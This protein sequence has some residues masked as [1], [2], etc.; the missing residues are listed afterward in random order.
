MSNYAEALE[1]L[2][3]QYEAGYL[4][5][6]EFDL[7]KRNLIKSNHSVSESKTIQVGDYFREYYVESLLEEG[8]WGSVYK[9]RHKF[10]F[11]HQGYRVLKVIKTNLLTNT[12]VRKRFLDKVNLVMGLEHPNVVKIFELFEE[13]DVSLLM[14]FVEGDSLQSLSA[15]STEQMLQWLEPICEAIDYIHKHGIVH[16]NIQPHNILFS[17]TRG[18]VILGFNFIT[19]FTQND[20]RLSNHLLDRIPYLAPEYF[21][22]STVEMTRNLDHY[23]VGMIVFHWFARQFPWPTDSSSTQIILLKCNEDLPSLSRFRSELK[24]TICDVVDSALYRDVSKR[25]SSST[26]FSKALKVAV[27]SSNPST[28]ALENSKS[29]VVAVPTEQEPPA[30]HTH[31]PIPSKVQDSSTPPKRTRRIKL[32]PRR[33]R[34]SSKRRPKPSDVTLH[35]AAHSQ[36]ESPIVEAS[37]PKPENQPLHSVDERPPETVPTPQNHVPSEMLEVESS[38]VDHIS[39]SPDEALKQRQDPKP[40]IAQST[41]PKNPNINDVVDSAAPLSDVQPSVPDSNLVQ[42]PL[43][44]NKPSDI[45]SVEIF[46]ID[47]DSL[48]EIF[49]AE[50]L[51]LD[52]VTAEVE[53]PTSANTT[54]IAPNS[55]QENIGS[56]NSASE[57]HNEEDTSTSRHPPNEPENINNQ[58]NSKTVN[59][60]WILSLAGILL[61]FMSFQVYSYYDKQ[62]KFRWQIEEII[63]QAGLVNLPRPEGSLNQQKIDGFKIFVEE[64]VALRQKVEENK[65]E[66]NALFVEIPSNELSKEKVDDFIKKIKDQRRHRK[67]WEPYRTKAEIF[68]VQLPNR[69]VTKEDVDKTITQWKEF[70]GKVKSLL[71]TKDYGPG[72]FEMGCDAAQLSCTE[73]EIPKHWVYLTRAYA[74]MKDEVSEELYHLVMGNKSSPLTK[75][76][77]MNRPITAVSWLNAVEFS[78]RLNILQELPQCYSQVS[79]AMW[80]WSNKDCTGWRLPTEAE[81]EY[82]AKEVDDWGDDS[83]CNTQICNMENNLREWVWDV[84]NSQTYYESSLESIRTDPIVDNSDNLRL[85]V[86]RGSTTESSTKKHLTERSSGVVT[87]TEH[88]LG[89]RLC[90]T[91]E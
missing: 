40:D 26:D 8:Y 30:T 62:A 55:I 86:N 76:N 7:L 60:R 29:S 87:N 35:S 53:M 73:D 37:T 5:R 51:N 88:L 25:Y 84:Y 67:H 23:G 19:T 22:S 36:T 9:V 33:K 74:M 75:S 48:D 6:T 43:E 79:E 61:A 38:R 28:P 32:F 1:K 89:F 90:R 34:N 58:S 45:E 68:N 69:M 63:A 56:V 82:T 27:Q 50:I 11:E 77:N 80:E 15:H 31:P 64:Q 42:E 72:V 39:N 44:A 83:R 49:E 59:V 52:Q 57:T 3:H 14:E 41:Q 12:T 21:G 78:T 16:G 81:W 10:S 66:A 85:R 71:Q 65:D 18:P 54:C 2:I 47:E 70:K 91:I 17:P 20:D 24:S 46:F 13:E 4:T